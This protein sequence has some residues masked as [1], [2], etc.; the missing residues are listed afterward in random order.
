MGRLDD[1]TQQKNRQ[2]EI[3]YF[4]QYFCTRQNLLVQIFWPRI[5]KFSLAFSVN[6][7]LILDPTHSSYYAPAMRMAGALCPRH[8]N[9]RGIKCYPCPSVLYL[10]TYVRLSRRRPLSK[11]NTFDQNFMKLG[12]IV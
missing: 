10:R 1:F 5:L 3:Q 7:G 9:G 11:W 8:D 4:D 12:H 6:A 2:I